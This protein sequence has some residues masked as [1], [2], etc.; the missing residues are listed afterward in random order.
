M[1]KFDLDW[2]HHYLMCPPDHYSVEYAINPWMDHGTTV[3]RSRAVHQWE[4]LVTTIERAGGLVDVVT[5][6]PGL[7]DMVFTANA[8]VISDRTF[9]PAS[10][11]FPERAREPE[12][13]AA[14]AEEQGFAVVPVAEGTFE[15]MG[16]LLPF[17]G[18]F[19]AGHG[20]RSN[21]VA[22]RTISQVLSTPVIDIALPEPR[23][24]HLD[25]VFTPLD[26]HSALIAPLGLTSAGLETLMALVPDPIL[27]TDAEALSFSANSIVVGGTVISPALSD[28]LS[29]ELRDRGF[30]P[31]VAPVGE[32]LKAGGAVRCLTLPLDVE[33]GADIARSA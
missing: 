6:D 12:L 28:R 20:H 2:G 7:P 25:L 32:F 14:W 19:V 16:D 4:R 15:G 23:F 11:R 1:Q 10:M 33:L 26:S 29:T 21:R 27:L 18:R 30:N 31:V 9:I 3:D 8:G 13:V 5:P 22:W 24:Y 17:A